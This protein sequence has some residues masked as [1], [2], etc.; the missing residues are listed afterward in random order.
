MADQTGIR[1]QGRIFQRGGVWWVAYYRS[2]KEIR[3]SANT[4]DRDKAEKHLH[5]R[6]E[7][8][9]TPT[10]DSPQAKKLRF[11][12]L[13][14][15]LRQDYKR[16]RNRSRLEFR[17]AQLAEV[18]AGD[19]A[20]AIT[21]A[22]IDRY[23]AAREEAK[24]RP[25]TIN[26]ELAALRRAFRLAVQK[27]LLPTMPA[28]TLLPEDNAR[29]GFIDPPEF[30]AL[31]AELTALGA[32]DIA[33]AAEFAYL[34][35]LR[36]GNVLGARWTWFTLE[37]D[38]TGAVGRGSVRLPGTVT[39]NKK[40]LS[41]ALTGPL[42]ALIARRWT[43]RLPDCPFVFHRQGRPL[44]RFDGPWTAACAAVG[45]P[46]LLFHDLRRS[47]AR[48]LRRAGVDEHVIQRIGGWKTPSMFKRY[49]IVDERDLRDA[50]ERLSTY[51]A[52]AT[53]A[54]PT[55]VPLRRRS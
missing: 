33:D 31:L 42:L 51:L 41:L 39:K 40:P 15:L 52:T 48:N 24:A 25:A 38:A 32:S 10:Y 27:Q 19:R 8:S 44:V 7:A 43:Q 34:T 23:V 46:G 28:V 3:E 54:A 37:V 47:G 49:D 26:R 29:E 5:K 12:D 2:G 53:T 20:L 13:C 16:K 36:R 50:G 45:L 22:R 4:T 14:E 30:A 18:F 35:C 11:E 55:V 21:T 17:L 6:R 1:G 9:K